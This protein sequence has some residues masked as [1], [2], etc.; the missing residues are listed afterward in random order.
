MN[1]AQSPRTAIENTLRRIRSLSHSREALESRWRSEFDRWLVDI[2]FLG[3][4]WT[5]KFAP[6]SRTSG[7]WLRLMSTDPT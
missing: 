3:V 7:S 4:D 5:R 1:D 6:A 2:D